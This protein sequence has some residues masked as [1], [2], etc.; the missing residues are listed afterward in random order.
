MGSLSNVQMCSFSCKKQFLQERTRVG[1]FIL[2]FFSSLESGTSPL[3]HAHTLIMEE[4]ATGRVVD[5][6]SMVDLEPRP[7][8][9][10]VGG[11]GKTVSEEGLPL[12]L[13]VDAER[14]SIEAIVRLPRMERVCLIIC[15][16]LLMLIFLMEVLKVAFVGKAVANVISGIN[17]LTYSV[18]KEDGME[19]EMDE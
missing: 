7:R 13:L 9:L 2:L 19:M 14:R 17:R 11:N 4:G 15:S 18:Y 10:V 12:L 5:A 3:P 6:V 8:A 16:I 1:F